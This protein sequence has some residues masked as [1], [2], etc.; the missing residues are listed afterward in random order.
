MIGQLNHVLA[1]GV[2]DWPRLRAACGSCSRRLACTGLSIE[3]EQLARLCANHHPAAGDERRSCQWTR[4]L[5]PPLKR[6][7]ARINADQFLRIP[8]DQQHVAGG[9][10][11][12]GQATHS[13]APTPQKL[14][15]RAVQAPQAAQRRQY[16]RRSGLAGRNLFER[17]GERH[18]ACNSSLSLG[19]LGERPNTPHFGPCPPLRSLRPARRREASS[20]RPG[21]DKQ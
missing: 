8:L 3:G 6:A 18:A 16:H 15:C 7:A 12:G 1:A 5:M 17:R 21:R 11:R 20:R 13:A 10:G 2:G 4:K 14:A 9:I 19:R